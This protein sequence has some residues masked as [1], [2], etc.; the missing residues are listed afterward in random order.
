MRKRNDDAA[1]SGDR[2][3][4]QSGARASAHDGKVV[5]LG[6]TDDSGDFFSRPRKDDQ[7]GTRLVN[8]AVV[9]VQRQVF[10]AGEIAAGAEEFIDGIAYRGGNHVRL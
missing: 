5:F 4:T 8:A 2:S 3:A 1:R 6:K 9:F 7:I 10:G